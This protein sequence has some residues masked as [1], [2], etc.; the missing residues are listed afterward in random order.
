MDRPG[1]DVEVTAW[2]GGAVE[3]APRRSWMGLVTRAELA[4]QNRA[5]DAW[6][7]GAAGHDMVRPVMRRFTSTQSRLFASLLTAALALAPLQVVHAGPS[8]EELYTQGQEKFD[9]GDYGSA[10][11]LWAEAV[12]ALPE[13]P[14]NSATRQTI[15][16]LSLDAYLRAYR[17]DDDRSHIDEA[18]ALLDEYEASLEATGAALTSEIASEKGKIDEILAKLAEADKPVE[19]PDDK[20][21]EPPIDDEPI[22]DEKPGKGLVIGGAVMIG[23]GVAGLGL[24]VGGMVGGGAAQKDYEQSI[25]GST[26]R[27]DIRKRGKTMN[28]LAIAG[29]VAGGVLVGAGVALLVLGLQRNKAARIGNVMLLPEAGP[30]YAGLGLTGRF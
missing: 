23:V 21:V 24:M 17:N 27:E 28:V 26:E 3:G 15:M 16:N 20:P 14:D 25:I 5:R 13:T 7:A 12:R 9:A 8:V 19:E 18:K 30:N 29:G 11:D 22:V 4:K 10:G 6:T 1:S 2:S